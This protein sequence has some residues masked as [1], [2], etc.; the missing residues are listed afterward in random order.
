M[1]SQIRSFI[2]PVTGAIVIR[3]GRIGSVH[4]KKNAE[5]KRV[6]MGELGMVAWFLF[7]SLSTF[8]FYKKGT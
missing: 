5:K 6:R 4:Y 2:V 8:D 1:K 3:F 7:F